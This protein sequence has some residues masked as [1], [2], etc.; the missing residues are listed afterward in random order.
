MTPSF[1]YSA[2]L[3][4]GFDVT[5]EKRAEKVVPNSMWDWWGFVAERSDSVLQHWS[6]H[7]K[8]MERS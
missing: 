4:E 3:G 6:D 8:T 5:Y 7:A 1:L 2:L